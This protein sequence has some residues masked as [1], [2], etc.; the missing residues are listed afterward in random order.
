MATAPMQPPA[1]IKHKNWFLSLAGNIGHAITDV[2]KWAPTVA[3][4]VLFVIQAE[5]KLTPE[6][7]ASLK[8]FIED[9]AMIAA[10]AAGAV[11]SRGTNPTLDVATFEAVEKLVKDFQVFYPVLQDVVAVLEGHIPQQAALNAEKVEEIKADNLATEQAK[12]SV[13]VTGSFKP[14][15]P[16]KAAK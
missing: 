8:L 2:F 15:E 14:V 11:A 1:T 4:K 5:E 6:F 12:P 16:V 10:T 13:G 7:L 9:G 3:N